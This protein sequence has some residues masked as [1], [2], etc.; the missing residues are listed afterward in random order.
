MKRLAL[1]LLFALSLAPQAGAQNG[2][3]IGYLNIIWARPFGIKSEADVADL[4]EAPKNRIGT[5]FI[6][7]MPVGGGPLL[8]SKPPADQQLDQQQ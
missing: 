2:E 3:P 8:P 6:V 7:L 4:K 1:A 5:G